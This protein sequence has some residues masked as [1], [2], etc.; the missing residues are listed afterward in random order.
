MSD[1]WNFYPLLVDDEPASIFVDIGIAG[2]VPM[3]DFPN[4]AYLRVRMQ[5]PRPDGLS[6]QDEYETLIA[7]ENDISSAIDGDDRSIYVGRNT[8]GGN[9]DFYFYTRDDRIESTLDAVMR[10]WKHYEYDTG[11]RPDPEWATYR[12]FLY[13]S[14][15]DLQRMANRDVTARLVENGD[16]PD[17][18]RTI[19]HFAFFRTERDRD[20]FSQFLVAEGYHVTG[21]TTAENG[22]FQIAFERT[23]SPDHIDEITIALCRAAS[24]NNGDYDGWGCVVVPEPAVPAT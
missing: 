21:A 12:G 16:H 2:S 23:D 18:A 11:T 1:N 15:E 7:L 20:A 3:T 9:R 24:N 22:E 14:P 8:S 4:M 19:D 10:N 13:P 6:S 5:Q 17:V